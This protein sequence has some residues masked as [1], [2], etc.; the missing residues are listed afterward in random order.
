MLQWRGVDW[1]TGSGTKRRGWL[2][3][4]G[5]ETSLLHGGFYQQPPPHNTCYCSLH[6]SPSSFP[7][8]ASWRGSLQTVMEE[9]PPLSLSSPRITWRQRF[10]NGDNFATQRT[11]HVEEDFFIGQIW[12]K[13]E[14]VLL[15]SSGQRPGCCRTPTPHRT[16]P[17]TKEFPIPNVCNAKFRAPSLKDLYNWLPEMLKQEE[18]ENKGKVCTRR[19]RKQHVKKKK[20]A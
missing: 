2:S 12:G 6:D 19:E 20:V 8:W 18:W 5:D 13:M 1:G 14:W 11:H 4:E 16:E 3:W 9:T 17:T 7:T 10:S 15:P